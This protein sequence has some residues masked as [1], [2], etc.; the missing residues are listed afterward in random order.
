MINKFKNHFLSQKYINFLICI[1]SLFI[2]FSIFALHFFKAK[3][4]KEHIIYFCLFFFC[5]VLFRWIIIHV[6]SKLNIIHIVFHKNN[7]EIALKCMIIMAFNS[8]IYWIAFYPANMF[9]DTYF[10]FTQIFGWLPPE[11]WHNYGHTLFMKIIMY[12]TGEPSMIVFVQITAILYIKYILF[13]ELS[14]LG[15]NKKLLY[16]IAFILSINVSYGLQITN[17]WK[18]TLFTIAQLYILFFLYKN[19]ETK[20][21]NL[22]SPIIGGIGFL[23]VLL[24]R[25][26]GSFTCLIIFGIMLLLS[27]FKKNIVV[28]CVIIYGSYLIFT[29][30]GYSIMD[31]LP[32]SK[33][34][35]YIP[36]LHGIAAVEKEYGSAGLDPETKKIMDELLPEEIWRDKYD[37]YDFGPYLFG[38]NDILKRKCELFSLS[39]ILSSYIRTLIRHPYIIIKDKLTTCE[40]IWNL[41]PPEDSYNF[42]IGTE[43][44]N[45]T[46][47]NDAR[48]SLNFNIQSANANNITNMIHWCFDHIYINRLL[49]IIHFRPVWLLW[50]LSIIIL[51]SFIHN[52]ISAILVLPVCINTV[53]LLIAMP[54]PDYRYVWGIFENV[55]IIVLLLS[56]KNIASNSTADEREQIE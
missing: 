10:Q 21:V 9:T 1:I 14:I 53:T 32:N 46:F 33:V 42:I 38:I 51:F 36:M 18:D 37:P 44:D 49:N 4:A 54:S 12:I 31:V 29:N 7:N 52:P 23:G 41:I 55:P 2:S 3:S 56:G 28:F 47:E 15:Y 40:L 19:Y 34:T 16:I 24:F 48:L 45:S 5:G 6:L 20:F 30:Y 8:I 39:D 27:K 43:H 26:N 13:K 17:I 35:I 22:H 50:I 11:N 25:H